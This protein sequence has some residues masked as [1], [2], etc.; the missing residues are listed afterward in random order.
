MTFGTASA[1]AGTTLPNDHVLSSPHATSFWSGEVLDYQ[2]LCICIS[3]PA[4]DPATTTVTCV[5][6]LQ[7]TPIVIPPRAVLLDTLHTLHT[8]FASC[9]AIPCHH[10]SCHHLFSAL[11]PGFVHSVSHFTSLCS[12]RHHRRLCRIVR[13][14]PRPAESPTPAYFGISYHHA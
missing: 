8:P 9:S 4:P 3:A 2:L 7:N 12:L 6:R 11:T 5:A 14:F 13:V 10:A 1:M